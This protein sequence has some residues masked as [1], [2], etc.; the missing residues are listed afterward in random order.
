M[1]TIHF[2]IRTSDKEAEASVYIRAF[3][4]AREKGKRVDIRL[5]TEI[6]VPSGRWDGKTETVSTNKA[7][8]TEISRF[9]SINELMQ[10]LK[11]ELYKVINGYD[12]ISADLLKN[13]LSA[14]VNKRFSTLPDAPADMVEYIEWLISEM[15]SGNRLN[16]GKPYDNDTIKQYGNILGVVKRFRQHFKEAT[17]NKLVWDSFSKRTTADIYMRYLDS[18]G[19]SVSSRNKYVSAMQVLLRYAKQ[20]GR[21]QHDGANLLFQ[22]PERTKDE[23]VKVYLTD[24]EIQA[25]YD[26]K[27]EPGSTYDK[28]RDIFLVGCYTGQRISDYSRISKD[29]FKTT[30]LGTTVVHLF[31]KK[32]GK[33]ILVPIL[34]GNLLSIMEKYDGYPP[35]IVDQVLNRY[36]KE[37]LEI[38]SDEVPS[39]QEYYPT[40]LTM[41]EKQAEKDGKTEYERDEQGNVIRPKYELVSSHTARRSCLTNLYKTHKFSDRLLM[42]ISGHKSRETFYKYILVSG[43]DVAE[44]VAQKLEELKQERENELKSNEHLFNEC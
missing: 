16:K 8:A 30:K 9:N 19:Y 15:K 25:L 10:D 17:G 11:T 44:E 21:H 13:A 37:I 1:A 41:K 14:F 26:M 2:Y 5:N 3:C 32:T 33:E 34:N 28:V 12:D 38:L 20:D 40:L 18:Y 29:N 24:E 43:E 39:L 42:S 35:K 31:Q 22:V 23:K 27:L 4:S 36:V 7:T 6:K